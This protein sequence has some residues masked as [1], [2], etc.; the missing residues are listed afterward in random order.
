[1]SISTPTIADI[2]AQLGVPADRV[3]LRPTPGTATVDDVVAL[4]DRENRLCELVDGVLVEKAMGFKESRLALV[5]GY[6]LESY[7]EDHDLG[8]VLGA[9]GMLRLNPTLVRIPDLSFISWDQLPDREYPDAKV[10][11]LYPDLAVEVLS[12]SNTPIEMER[13]LRDYF[14]AGARLVWYLDP[15]SRTARVYTSPEAMTRLDE[16]QALDGGEV[17]PGFRLVI[18]DWFVRA[19]RPGRIG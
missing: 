3:L 12:A 14:A 7:L 9:D 4:N 1:M 15:V 11:S 2:V 10:P 18:N 13:K 8:M 5:L 16:S 19:K 17:L 6:I